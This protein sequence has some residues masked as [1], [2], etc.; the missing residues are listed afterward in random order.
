MPILFPTNNG[1]VRECISRSKEIP[2]HHVS[3]FVTLIAGVTVNKKEL[4]GGFKRLFPLFRPILEAFIRMKDGTS[5]SW[6]S[7][8][9]ILKLWPFSGSN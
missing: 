5:L 8:F 4:V 7:A 1:T 6:P 3:R 9:H 2:D